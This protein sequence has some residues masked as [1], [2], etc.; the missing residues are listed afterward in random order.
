MET[1]EMHNSVTLI[2]LPLSVRYSMT[3]SSLCHYARERSNCREL[4]PNSGKFRCMRR[5]QNIHFSESKPSQNA[6]FLKQQK[7]PEDVYFAATLT[8]LSSHIIRKL[9]IVPRLSKTIFFK[10]TK[11]KIESVRS[12][13]LF[14]I[15]KMMQRERKSYFRDY[16]ECFL[17]ACST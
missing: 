13:T 10:Q 4:C 8:H 6:Q 1:F 12:N 5:F 17:S 3:I 15:V 9:K 7:S 16:H 2:G 11:Y 14:Y